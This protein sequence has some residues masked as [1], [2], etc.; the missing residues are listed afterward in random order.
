[1][2]D[3]SDLKQDSERQSDMMIWNNEVEM[4]KQG[5]L[6]EKFKQAKTNDEMLELSKHVTVGVWYGDFHSPN[7]GYPLQV[8]P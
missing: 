6:L 4:A 3:A 2:I 5:G 1:M 7:D 8:E